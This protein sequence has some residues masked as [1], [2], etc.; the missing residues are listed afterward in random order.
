MMGLL[1]I[2]IQIENIEGLP[3]SPCVLVANHQSALDL[4]VFGRIVPRR[5]L[6]IAKRELRW[7]PF[8]GWALW[9]GGNVFIHRARRTKALAGMDVALRKL[10]ESGN[11]IWIFP[12]GTRRRTRDMPLLPFKKGAFHLAIEAGVP[13][14]PIV[15]ESFEHIVD[16]RLKKAFHSGT[17]RMRVLAPISTSGLGAADVTALSENVRHQM[18][19]VLEEFVSSPLCPK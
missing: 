9:I 5:T 13:I 4:G 10:K 14:V 16:W 18:L 6:V 3:Q 17:I 7:V 19:Q 15:A 11:H 2:R 1:R 12:E 8:L